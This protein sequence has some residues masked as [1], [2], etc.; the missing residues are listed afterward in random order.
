[1]IKD[2]ALLEQS[3]KEKD[4]DI[5]IQHYMKIALWLFKREIPNTG[6]YTSLLD[7]VSS[8]N[9]ELCRFGQTRDANATYRSTTTCTEFMELMAEVLDE[10]ATLHLKNS[11]ATIGSWSLMA[12]ETSMHGFSMLGI[13]A[14]YFDINSEHRVVEEMIDCCP[15]DSTKVE[16]LFEMVDKCLRIR[17]LDFTK[18][19]CVSFDGAAV[20][21][22]PI[23]G[24]YGLMR[25]RWKL[26]KLAELTA[27]S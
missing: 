9:G 6:N 21:S 11:I 12:D 25:S 20:M 19:K 4:Y 26:P 2:K 15:I 24:L 23:N 14:R 13:Y 10:E 18:L 27:C 7:L 22:S 3:E 8:F 17:D 1:M 5:F 16:C